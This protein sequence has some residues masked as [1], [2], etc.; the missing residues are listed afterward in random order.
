MK[1]GRKVVKYINFTYPRRID[2]D[3]I[4]V[5]V[6]GGTKI[7]LSGERFLLDIFRHFLPALD[8]A[9]LDVG[10]NLGQTLAKVKLADSGRRYYGF[11]PNPV[12]F[13]Y[14]QRLV[15]DNAWSDVTLF[16]VALGDNATVVPL[17]VSPAAPTDSRA[18]LVDAVREP[19]TETVDRHVA[20]F[21][22]STI[23]RLI[24][25]PVALIKVDVEGSELEVLIGMEGRLRRDRP[26]ICIEFLP[27]EP[28]AK[29]QERAFELLK[30]HRYEIFQVL[31]TRDKRWRG[32]LPTP[33]YERNR[34]IN[35]SDFVAVHKSRI[36]LL[37][38][39][40]VENPS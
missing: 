6:I 2:G 27:L 7:G 14:L 24:D 9:T 26:V 23:D 34:K 18:S 19:F 37:D 38:G 32:L 11:E 3:W 12:C 8:G 29:Q 25:E 5:P 36:R 21:E 22:F 1:I 39:L 15:A 30:A 40:V 4:N 20:V 31:K 16:P 33:T 13:S 35:E 10:A 28:L 17:K